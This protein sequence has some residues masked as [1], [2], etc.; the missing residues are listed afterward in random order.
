MSSM[1]TGRSSTTRTLAGPRGVQWLARALIVGAG[2]VVIGRRAFQC[3]T[4]RPLVRGGTHRHLARIQRT[5]SSRPAH[6][7]LRTCMQTDPR[8]CQPTPTMPHRSNRCGDPYGSPSDVINVTRRIYLVFGLS[9][10]PSAAGGSVSVSC[11]YMS[12]F[13]TIFSSSKLAPPTNICGRF[14]SR[15][16]PSTNSVAGSAV[17]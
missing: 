12:S 8:S 4:S 14:Q 13:S 15:P 16:A 1:S 5:P 9:E 2:V 7:G 3:K 17:G 10:S 6:G 11:G